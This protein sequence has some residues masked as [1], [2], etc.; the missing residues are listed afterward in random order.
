MACVFCTLQYCTLDYSIYGAVPVRYR[1]TTDAITGATAA[2][3]VV[4]IV[5]AV[6]CDAVAVAIVAA[7]TDADAIGGRVCVCAC[8][9]G[10]SYR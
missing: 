3:T 4:F 7:A 10:R 5:V 9:G 1:S 6:A 2:T 8:M